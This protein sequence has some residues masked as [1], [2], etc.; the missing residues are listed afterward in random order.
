MKLASPLSVMTSKT[1]KFYLNLNNYRN[2]HYAVLNKAKK[3]YKEL[4]RPQIEKLPLL[5]TICIE[6]VVYPPT[7][8]L[9]DIGNVTA[10]HKKFFEDALVELGVIEDDNYQFVLGSCER[11]GHIDKENPRVQINI[12]EIL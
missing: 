9:F 4:M 3:V 10:V 8:R 11:F 2:T 6:Y 5:D 7:K 1:K 12:V